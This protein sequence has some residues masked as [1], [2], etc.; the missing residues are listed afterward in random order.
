MPPIGN[1]ICLRRTGGR[2]VRVGAGQVAAEHLALRQPGDAGVSTSRSIRRGAHP[3]QIAGR[4]HRHE[5]SL[6]SPAALQQ[7]VRE[8]RPRAE[9]GDR[10]SI[11][12]VRLP[13]SCSR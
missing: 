4:D 5:R 7:P 1:L 8:V 11:V 10:H 12:P 13:H 3:E 2:A 9:L 6:G